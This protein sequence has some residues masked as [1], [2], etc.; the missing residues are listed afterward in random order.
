MS[1]G[2]Y[3]GCEG[4]ASHSVLV[5]ADAAGNILAEVKGEGTNQWLIGLDSSFQISPSVS[6][7][8]FFFLFFFIHFVGWGEDSF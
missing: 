6:I 4:G 2:Y 8:F 1:S 3:A 7:L 5:L